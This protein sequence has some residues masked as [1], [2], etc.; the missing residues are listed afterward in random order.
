MCT[1]FVQNRFEKA[2][3][4]TSCISWDY[5]NIATGRFLV[6]IYISKTTALVVK[7]FPRVWKRFSHRRQIASG[8]ELSI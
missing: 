5:I 3:R 8:F 1:N 2:T 6:Y 7:F 4:C